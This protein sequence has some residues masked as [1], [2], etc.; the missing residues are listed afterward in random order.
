VQIVD[1]LRER[2]LSPHPLDD[3]YADVRR[4]WEDFDHALPDGESSRVAQERAD[5][6][7]TD[8]AGRHPGQTIVAA[9]HGNLIALALARH[10]PAVGFD[11][12]DAMPLP[13]LYELELVTGEP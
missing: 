12:W 11:F 8:L 9:S 6:V 1:D 10:D 13:A 3:W 7:L 4:T 2:L 5:R